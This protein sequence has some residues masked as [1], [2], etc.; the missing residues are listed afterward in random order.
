MEKNEV[1]GECGTYG[2]QERSVCQLMAAAALSA[3][4]RLSK[5]NIFCFKIAK[6]FKFIL[7]IYLYI[8]IYLI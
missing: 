4:L 1:G 2:R 7:F 5:T 6:I 8:L 3:V